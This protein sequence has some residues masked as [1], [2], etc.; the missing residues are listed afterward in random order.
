MR[1]YLIT[2]G[3][4]FIGSN[5]VH[6]LLDRYSDIRVV[7]FDKLTYAGNLD[8]LLDVQDDP[9]YHFI[10]GDIRDKEAVAQAIQAHKIDTIVNFAA[11]SHVDRSIMDPDAFIRTD[12]YGTYVLLEAA[13]KHEIKRFHQVSS[14]TEDTPLLVRDERTHEISLRPI[15]DLANIPLD[16]FSV[17]TLTSDFQVA[18]RRMGHLISHPADEIYEIT[19]NGGGRIRATASHSVFVFEDGQIVAKRSDQ[20]KNGDLMVTFLGDIGKMEKSP[21]V[22]DLR[23]LFADYDTEWMD[24]SLARRWTTLQALAEGRKP[25]EV[26]QEVGTPTF[27]RLVQELIDGGY[28]QP[29]NGVYQGTARSALNAYRV[30]SDLR[31]D[32]IRRQLH[33]P[34][35]T[36]T[37]SPLLM[38][39]FGL[40]LAE[41]HASHTPRELKGK[42]RS[43]TFTINRTETEALEKL[44]TCAREIFGIEPYIREHDSTYQVRYSSYWVHALFRQFGATAETKRLPAWIW[45]QP[46]V[47]IEAFLRGYEGDARIQQ[48]G[49]C[50]FTTINR[51]LAE[52]LVWLARLNDINC[53]I[54]QRVTQQIAGQKPPNVTVTRERVCWDIT[55]SAE[56]YHTIQRSRWRAPMARCLPTQH[57]VQ[58]LGCRHRR[59]ISLG[60]K[61]LVSKRQAQIFLDSLEQVPANIRTLVNSD[62]GVAK[63]K[64]IRRIK[65]DFT[66]YDVSVPGSERFFGGN[67]PCLLHNTDEVYGQVLAGSSKETDPLVPRSPYAASKASADLM[68]LAYYITYGLPVTITRGANNIGPFQHPEKVVPLFVTNAIDDLPL[69]VYGDGRQLRDY[70]YVLDHCEAIDIVLQRGRIGEIYN[71]GTG[72]EMENLRM[73][74]ILLDELGKPRTLIRHV[75]DRPGHDRRYSLNVDKLKALGWQPRHTHEEAIR[76]TVR[77]YVEN[78]WWWRKIKSGEFRE[79]YQ[80]QYGQRL[81]NSTLF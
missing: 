1:N 9:R 55:V 2:G 73:V 49:Q 43:V 62:I 13:K 77:W 33:I 24:D 23:A 68:V 42:N 29:V 22:F 32:L 50:H 8:N 28:L 81:A 44:V 39:V 26:A 5:F 21:H 54:N 60:Y 59:S 66:V 75:E 35:E 40:Y 4:G 25:A 78:E 71:V 57:L 41:G 74:E 16:Q 11:E 65:G 47:Y 3:A 37:V 53:R 63:I 69:P 72:Q 76:K 20:L 36:L 51:A 27:Y 7:V 67:V 52:S 45:S 14:V 12:V 10:R 80:R 34:A 61:Q 38:E 18:F 56:Q 17:L 48:D 15:A 79:Y 6:Y 64:S 46:K 58:A 31:W 70:Q 19:Y 30:L